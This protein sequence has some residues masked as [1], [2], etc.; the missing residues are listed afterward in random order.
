MRC[1]SKLPASAFLLSYAHGN[2]MAILSVPVRAAKVVPEAGDV[3]AFEKN[4]KWYTALVTKVEDKSYKVTWGDGSS[5]ELA[6]GPFVIV[7]D[8]PAPQV[9]PMPFS[10]VKKHLLTKRKP[11]AE[12]PAPVVNPKD[13]LK[14]A[15]VHVP[16]HLADAYPHLGD[17]TL[18][19]RKKQLWFMDQLWRYYNQDKFHGKLKP[20]KLELMKAANPKS[21]KLR[22]YWSGGSRTL[23]LSPRLFN[24]N[25]K[26][27]VAILLHE[28]CHQAVSDVSWATMT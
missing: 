15:P 2:A 13:K 12:V 21:M 24:A 16:Q 5:G 14:E 11:K 22:G 3:V 27:F 18:A 9:P 8:L 19:N 1:V 6:K 10:T 26:T 23:S 17:H 20:C 7:V 4:S 25:L 28:M